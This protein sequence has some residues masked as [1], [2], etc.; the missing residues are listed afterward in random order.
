[1]KRISVLL[2][3]LALSSSAFAVKMGYVNSQELFSKYSQTKIIQENLNKEKSRLENELK[4]KEISLQKMQ[5]E[6][7]GKG[8]AATEQE[9]KSFQAKVDEFQKLVRDSQ[10][11]LNKEE[12][13]RLQEVERLINTAVQNVAKTDKYDYVLEQGAVKYGGENITE[14]VLQV[15]EK[16]KKIK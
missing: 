11:K 1:M 3:G 14:K 10:T 7:Q 9:K 12:M 16:T 15:M 2:I 5:V 8:A 13:T 6:L 4:Q